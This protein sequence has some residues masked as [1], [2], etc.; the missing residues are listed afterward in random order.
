[1]NFSSTETTGTPKKILLIVRWP[2]G[3]IRT[4]IRYV[5][6]N[7]D[8][9]KWHLTILAPESE[10]LNIIKQ[11]LLGIGAKYISV[12][13]IP[14]DGSSGALILLK[15]TFKELRNNNYDLVHS[16]GFISGAC[17]AIPSLINHLPH[18]M[19]S[20]D[21]I[22][23]NQ[24][25]GLKGKIKKIVLGGVFRLIN[26]IHSVSHDAHNNFI[27][28]FPIFKTSD[29]C[30]VI[31][32]GIEIERFNEAEM[33][34]LKS[35][36]GTDEGFF[37]I[38]FLGRFM[39]QKGFKYLIEAI[40]ILKKNELPLKPVVITFGDGGFASR[41][42]KH[43]RDIGLEDHFRFMPFTPNIAS[44]IKGLDLIAMPSLW[45]ACPLQPMEALVCG[46]PFV[47][48]DCVGLREVLE[49]TPAITVPKANSKELAQAI[50]REI[51]DH[52]KSI[53]L[54]FK[55]EAARRY[56]VAKTRS[57]IFQLYE[58]LTNKIDQPGI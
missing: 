53:F 36:T 15:K 18:I 35:E 8:V 10:G 43:I 50:I 42:K 26:Q 3:G 46:T 25:F 24:F 30:I 48:T 51:L 16:H 11:D 56:D 54:D 55:E 44:T 23:E 57:S 7:I 45:E 19:T 1:M 21:V 58:K 34:D 14:S 29:K 4:F 37:L 28:N 2:G 5:Y 52:R 20:H 32:N 41:D 40:E 13:G 33:R 6:H 49:N 9:S 27:E 39:S 22:N 12:A 47:G 31:P 38:G 17:A